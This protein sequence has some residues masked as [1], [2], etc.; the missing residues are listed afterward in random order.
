MSIQRRKVSFHLLSPPSLLFVVYEISRHTN[1]RNQWERFF[2]HIY[3]FSFVVGVD[4]WHGVDYEIKWVIVISGKGSPPHTMFFFEYS[5]WSMFR[6]VYSSYQR[7]G[8]RGD[9]FQYRSL[10]LASR[11]G[12]GLEGETQLEWRGE[13][14]WNKM[15]IDPLPIR[16]L[17][18]K[19]HHDW[20]FARKWPSPVYVLY[21]LWLLPLGY[22]IKRVG[23]FASDWLQKQT[24]N[25]GTCRKK[26]G[27]VPGFSSFCVIS[28]LLRAN[29]VT[30]LNVNIQGGSLKL[31][32]LG[33]GASGRKGWG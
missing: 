24:I 31:Q 7:E 28:Q 13:I 29:D 23:S 14:G 21:S 10:Y 11:A 32:E 16:K 2:P 1:V 17:G 22:H 6:P 19:C 15:G 5:L 20:M 27:L 30:Y 26:M 9:W 8:E 3:P 12:E 4:S 33:G 25:L 18:R